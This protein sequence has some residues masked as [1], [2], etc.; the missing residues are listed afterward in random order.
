MPHIYLTL[1]QPKCIPQDKYVAIVI[2]NLHTDPSHLPVLYGG[3]IICTKCGSTALNKLVNLSGN[4]Q[5]TCEDN[6]SYGSIDLKRYNKG[7]APLGYP[8]WPYNKLF[9]SHTQMIR[10][11]QSQFNGSAHSFCMPAQDPSVSDGEDSINGDVDV[12]LNG[13]ATS[14]SS[15]SE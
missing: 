13:S 8:N 14:G 10:S 2:S 12:S 4:C 11:I 3:V 15:S 9:A 7:K 1:L 5:G 6:K